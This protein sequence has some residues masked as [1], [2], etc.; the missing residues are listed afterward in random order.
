M[1]F[2]LVEAAMRAPIKMAS[3]KVLM[4]ALAE[5]AN[6]DGEC[7][8]SV[9]GLVAATGM[10]EAQVHRRRRLMVEQ[11]WLSVAPRF[12]EEGRQRSNGYVL[13]VARLMGEGVT[14][15]TGGRVSLLTPPRVSSGDTP[16]NPHKE[17]SE[18]YM[19]NRERELTL[20]AEW[21]RVY[22]RR[23]GRGQAIKAFHGA[24]KKVE[25]A[26]L[27]AATAK[28]ATIFAAGDPKFIPYPATWLN[29]ERWSDEPAPKPNGAAKPR[30]VFF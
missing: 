19:P 1:T 9:A 20:F 26:A 12:S 17:P 4:I 27:L 13:N 10:S 25:P 6:D 5:R 16:K 14:V 24:L 21:W 15:D 2:R 30:Q 29:G 3:A 28:A 18:E 11:G 23:V 8:P 7:W 22:P